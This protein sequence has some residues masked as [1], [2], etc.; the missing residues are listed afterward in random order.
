MTGDRPRR[1]DAAGSAQ[2]SGNPWRPY[3]GIDGW[4]LIPAGVHP[5]WAVFTHITGLVF[6]LQAWSDA[7]PFP[8]ELLMALLLAVHA[9]LAVAW[10]RTAQCAWTHHRSFPKRYILLTLAELALGLA[11][12]AAVAA[13]PDAAVAATGRDDGFFV[14]LSGLSVAVWVPYMLFSKRVRATYHREMPQLSDEVR[15]AHETIG[16]VWVAGDLFSF[17]GGLYK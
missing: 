15:Q 2:A 1:G 16:T 6:L 9:A 4:L 17:I 12:V 14:V 7:L 10:T 13:F 8:L 5:L 3:H 11:L